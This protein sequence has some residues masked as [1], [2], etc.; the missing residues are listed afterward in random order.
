MNLAK[1][2]SNELTKAENQEELQKH[3]DTLKRSIISTKSILAANNLNDLYT[4][5]EVAMKALFHPSRCTHAKIFLVKDGETV[6]DFDPSSM[7]ERQINRMS[8]TMSRVMVSKKPVFTSLRDGLIVMPIL[9]DGLIS[10]LLQLRGTCNNRA[11]AIDQKSRGAETRK[12]H[13]QVLVKVMH[14]YSF[15]LAFTMK[16]I[17]KENLGEIK[18]NKLSSSFTDLQHK[19][20]KEKERSKAVHDLLREMLVLCMPLSFKRLSAVLHGIICGN[21]NAKTMRIYIARIEQ[22]KVIEYRSVDCTCGVAEGFVGEAAASGAESDSSKSLS[23][24]YNSFSKCDMPAPTPSL[25]DIFTVRCFPIMSSSRVAGNV[26]VV[27]IACMYWSATG[28]YKR[29]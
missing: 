26:S 9:I 8:E 14:H 25:S 24:R 13:S 20:V 27:G 21:T 17:N 22:H 4:S 18:H 1:K 28:L 11:S 5:T 3:V 12:P 23:M 10:A 19:Y 16:R 7:K 29:K 6:W 2:Y 15:V